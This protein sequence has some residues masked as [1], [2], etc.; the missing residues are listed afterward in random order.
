MIGDPAVNGTATTLPAVA[1][2][3][4]PIK[5]DVVV[6]EDGVM[7]CFCDSAGAPIAGEDTVRFDEVIDH[8]VL[9]SGVV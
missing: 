8:A 4:T 6:I 1:I 2:A 9:K 5:G 3:G 7:I